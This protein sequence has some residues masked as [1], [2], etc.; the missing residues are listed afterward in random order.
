MILRKS[1]SAFLRALRSVPADTLPA[2]KVKKLSRRQMKRLED[3]VFARIAASENRTVFDEFKAVPPAG[4][5]RAP[6]RR[7]GR[8]RCQTRRR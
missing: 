3:A 4:C 8:A 5:G 1:P 7:T 2:L 6:F